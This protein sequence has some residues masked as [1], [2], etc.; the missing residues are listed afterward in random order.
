[1][2]ESFLEIAFEAEVLNTEENEEFLDLAAELCNEN[3]ATRS[4]SLQELRD[5]IKD[6]GECTPFRS[7]DKFLL[8]FLRSRNYIV[9]KAHRL[10]VR[11]CTLREQYPYLWQDVDLWSLEKVRDAYEGTIYDRPDI[12]RISIF[13]FGTWDPNEYP[14]E[15][16][17]KAGASQVEIGSRQPKLQIIGGTLIVDLE[18]IT[19][20][21]A[22][23]LTPTVAYQIVA[24]LGLATPMRLKSCHFINYSWLLNSFFY[25]FKKFI[26]RDFVNNIYFHGHDLKSLQQHIPIECLPERYGGTCKL[27]CN[28]STWLNK[29]KKYRTQEFDTEMKRLGYI[30]KE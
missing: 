6:R 8:K 24:L 14:I 21:H 13:R 16:L 27:H 19:L 1:M 28:Y 11:Y 30:I 25:L 17:V 3:I 20:R 5:M 15:D 7:D 12:G 2:F 29:I 10:L 23:T 4:E 26:P 9:P 18:G 22:A